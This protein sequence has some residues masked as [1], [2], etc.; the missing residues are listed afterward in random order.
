MNTSLILLIIGIFLAVGVIVYFLTRHKKSSISIQNVSNMRDTVIGYKDKNVTIPVL[1][2]MDGNYS[3]KPQ[4]DANLVVYDNAGKYYWNSYFT[5]P[6]NFFRCDPVDSC[7]YTTVLQ[8]DG[9][10]VTYSSKNNTNGTN[11]TWSAQTYPGTNFNKRRDSYAPYTLKFYNSG[12]LGI[13]DSNNNV[14]WSTGDVPSHIP[15]PPSPLPPRPGCSGPDFTGKTWKKVF[16]ITESNNTSV[17][18]GNLG[19]IN[20]NA[21]FISGVKSNP[22]NIMTYNRYGNGALTFRISKDN[23]NTFNEIDYFSKNNINI[24]GFKVF[25][26][27]QL[28]VDS[29]NK[30]YLSTDGF[31][32]IKNTFDLTKISG[33][34]S[35]DLPV[36]PL[37]IPIAGSDDGSHVYIPIIYFWNKSDPNQF[38]GGIA[39][40]SVD[41]S[42]NVTGKFYDFSQHHEINTITSSEDGKVVGLVYSD[43]SNG[44]CFL[45]SQ[46]Y[47]E[48]WNT[49]I[50]PNG[51]LY[52]YGMF[53]ISMNNDGSIMTVLC[54]SFSVKAPVRFCSYDSGKTWEEKNATWLDSTALTMSADGWIQLG[55]STNNDSN[56]IFAF[57]SKDL[58]TTWWNGDMPPSNFE[59][60][61]AVDIFMSYD[62]SKIYVLTDSSLW[63]LE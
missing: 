25:D 53:Q 35:V 9:N 14:I 36:Y 60:S 13:Y 63:S 7:T 50:P 24:I 15:V 4:S 10:L 26:N 48:T 22:Q 41:S 39:K 21:V 20:C 43:E 38:A 45:I 30:V 11:Y 23:G 12:Q 51:V 44:S 42:F 8:P 17:P 46:D 1:I 33:F 37:G 55:V 5:D 56:N 49:I 52:N 54:Y 58:G 28:T 27:F 47:G 40:L 59:T 6:N 61:S 32:T 2:S 18:I 34:P 31:D 57:R 19:N 29:S 3:L 62:Y 16:S